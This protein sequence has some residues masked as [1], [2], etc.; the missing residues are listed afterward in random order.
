MAARSRV[1]AIVLFIRQNWG[2]EEAAGLRKKEN[3]LPD[4]EKLGGLGRGLPGTENFWI[5]A[6]RKRSFFLFWARDPNLKSFD[7]VAF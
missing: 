1:T 7:H 6:I 2:R 4:A 3:G 5:R